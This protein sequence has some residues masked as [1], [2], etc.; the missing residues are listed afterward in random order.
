[1]VPLSALWLPILL[2]AVIVFVAS[3]VLH[4][5]VPLH[6][7]DYRPLPAEDDV[8][9]ALRA[10]NIPPGDYVFPRPA[11]P[12]AMNA[13]EFVEKMKKGPVAV[14]TVMPSGPPSMGK[15][16]A[17]WFAYCVLVSVFAAY[18]AGRSLGVGA[19]YLE[20]FRFAGTVAFAI[21]GLYSLPQS[22][23]FQ[24]S[25]GS[26]LRYAIDGLV[27]GLLTAGTFGWLWPR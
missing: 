8:M 20:A 25:W 23:W 10:F 3:F 26:T 15:N 2:S 22:I 12:S 9:G 7:N 14:M 27:Y 19:H 5:L 18:I 11:S 24:R 1:M 13:P 21:Y 16:L 6:R 4:M 17:Q